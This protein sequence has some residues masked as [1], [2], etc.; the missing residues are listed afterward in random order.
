MLPASYA[1]ANDLAP[2]KGIKT[3]SS[4]TSTLTQ[5]PAND[6]APQKGIKT[7]TSQ[8]GQHMMYCGQ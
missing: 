7:D 3:T 1:T 4:Y 2:Q 8:I 6:L 5:S